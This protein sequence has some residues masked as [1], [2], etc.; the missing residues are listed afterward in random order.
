MSTTQR[1]PEVNAIY[2]EVTSILEGKSFAF[3]MNF[4]GLTVAQLSDLRK[5]LGEKN[6]K[7]AVIKNSLIAKVAT[8]LGW[9][10][11]SS[12]LVGPTAVITGEGDVA[13]IAKT[14]AD[15]VKANEKASIKGGQLDKKMLTQVDVMKLSELISL[16]AQQAR[17]LGTLQAPASKMARVLQ[18]KI[19]A[20]GE[21]APA[22]APAA[23]APAEAAPAAETPAPDGTP[24]A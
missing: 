10:D 24:A 7:V 17:L 20:A 13:D 12:M 6:C 19:D 4:G 23:E 3:L 2:R 1:R 21:A 18:A 9:E 15:F 16:A 8:D 22:E 5:K 14:L 11:L